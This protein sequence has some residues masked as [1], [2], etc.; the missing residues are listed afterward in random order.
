MQ[1][2]IL[3]GVLTAPSEPEEGFR[4]SMGQECCRQSRERSECVAVNT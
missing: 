4:C 1:S 2:E 3:F